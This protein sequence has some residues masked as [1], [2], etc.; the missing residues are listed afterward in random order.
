MCSKI[1]FSMAIGVSHFSLFSDMTLT[2]I[3]YIMVFSHLYLAVAD[4]TCSGWR[5]DDP[6]M[7]IFYHRFW[8][9]RVNA[10][11]FSRIVACALMWH[12]LGYIVPNFHSK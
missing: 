1:C 9:Q 12:S 10:Y 4:I 6:P 7:Q 5:Q 11:T 8:G 2:C 3:V